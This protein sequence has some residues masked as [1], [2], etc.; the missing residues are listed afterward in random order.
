[1]TESQAV[2][3]Q[4][5]KNPCRRCY[6]GDPIA[7]ARISNLLFS[8]LGTNPPTRCYAS[9]DL[10]LRRASQGLFD[11][12]LRRSFSRVFLFAHRLRNLGGLIFLE[13]LVRLQNVHGYPTLFSGMPHR[14]QPDSHGFEIAQ[15]PSN[16][17]GPFGTRVSSA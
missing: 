10:L 14:H 9:G 8:R 7:P 15:A 5:N 4:S 6:S 13:Q 3:R 16:L 12:Q 2:V 11:L 17:L 1:M